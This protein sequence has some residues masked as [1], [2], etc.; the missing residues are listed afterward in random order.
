MSALAAS[1]QTK[2]GVDKLYIINC[3]EGVAGDISRWSPGVN[4]GKSM[5]FV[6]N[7]YLIHHTQ[8][9]LLWDT[10]I[11][12]AIAAKPDGEAPADPR[13]THWRRPKTLASQLEMLGVKP[14]D[15][16]YVAV[17]HTHPDHIG[18]VE[19]FPQTMLLVQKAEYEWPS[20]LGVGRFKPEHP[21]TKL[22]G[23][24][25]VFGDGSV[26]LLATPGHTPG[27][28]SLLLKLPNTGAIV[29]SGDAVHFKSN[30]D[31]RRVPSGNTDKDKTLASMQR[32]ADILA[33]ENAQLW[34]N[35]DKAQRDTLKMA[36]AYYD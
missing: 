34:I 29:L 6:D 36:P 18:N 23:D 22:E 13:M 17:S 3:G 15:I 4:V 7:C 32:I 14:A 19:M 9:W 24:Y 1:A 20:P 5:D 21:V 28:Q 2:T 10:G 35:H 25:D 12:D 26:T 31:I 30:W 33:K 11:T 16:K 27:H 8:G